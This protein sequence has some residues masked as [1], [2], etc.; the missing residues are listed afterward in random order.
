MQEPIPF[1]NEMI[2]K[3][4]ATA[5]FKKRTFAGIIPCQPKEKPQRWKKPSPKPKYSSGEKVMTIARTFVK[6]PIRLA[7]MGMD[8]YLASSQ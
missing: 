8:R 4:C 5:V 6:Y 1:H 7:M 2:I 3:A